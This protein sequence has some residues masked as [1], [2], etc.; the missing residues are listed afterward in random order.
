MRF[1]TETQ[2]IRSAIAAAAKVGKTV[3]L[4]ADD[5]LTATATAE[6]THVTHTIDA[7][8]EAPG[9]VTVEARAIMAALVGSGS[10][11]VEL[12]RDRLHVESGIRAAIPIIVGQGM[13]R[14]PV[15]PGVNV[16][17]ALFADALRRASYCASHD[18]ARPNLRGVLADGDR[19]IA[20]DGHR[21]SC[22]PSPLN[23]D[24]EIIIPIESIPT[25]CAAL[26]GP[27]TIG[28][29]NGSI[30][31]TCG[32]VVLRTRAVDG[33][34]PNYRQVI[35]ARREPTTFSRASM[36][37]AV[38]AVAPFANPKTSVLRLSV[39]DE[40]ME[41]YAADPENG[42]AATQV[43]CV[44][45]DSAPI[46]VNHHYMT[47]ALGAIRCEE[48]EIEMDGPLSAVVMRDGDAVHVVMPMRI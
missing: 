10:A 44:G 2:A 34:F 37:A 30:T 9:T 28:S 25:I 46:G 32:P 3:T 27:A 45:A 11:S 7:D 48:V 19:L 14:T 36:L 12:K 8:I 22:V 21:L 38:K 18:E 13:E 17:G 41:L 31:V 4:Q 5:T 20:T 1:R 24:A 40:K 23:V 26:D 15:A 35:P 39:S 16:D 47:E 42:E 6:P 33:K 29:D 43:E